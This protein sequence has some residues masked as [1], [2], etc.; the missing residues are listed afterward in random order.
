MRT[1]LIFPMLLLAPF[2]SGA[3]QAPDST[4]LPGDGFSL[5]GALDLFKNAHDLD[6]FEHALNSTDSHVN[7][8]DL[9]DDG[10]VDYIHVRKQDDGDARVIVLQ[11]ALSKEEQQDVAV[12]ELEKTGNDQAMVQIRGD[13]ELYA[14]NTIIEPAEEVEEGVKGKG[15]PSAP[16]AQMSVWVN[17]WAWPSVQWCYSPMWGGWNSSW[18]WGYYPPW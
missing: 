13:D 10:E 14:E 17:V 8:L 2:A 9:N 7:N 6:S 18:Y 3:P 4:G 12:I 16:Y 5:Q 15:G 1:H 11:V